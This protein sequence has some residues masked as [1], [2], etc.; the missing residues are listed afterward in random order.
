MEKVR[1]NER[2]GDRERERE[3]E[4]WADNVSEKYIEV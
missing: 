3:R 1:D 4:S 2:K